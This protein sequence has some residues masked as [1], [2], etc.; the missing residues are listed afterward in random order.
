MPPSFVPRP[1]VL[2][3]SRPVGDASRRANPAP[4]LARQV[5]PTLGT[6]QQLQLRFEFLR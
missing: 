3:K 6:P 1:P 2:P 5:L 4:V